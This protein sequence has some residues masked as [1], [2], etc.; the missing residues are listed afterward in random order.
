MPAPAPIEPPAPRP[1][2]QQAPLPQVLAPQ[3]AAP[4][5]TPAA[6]MPP[7]PVTPSAAAPPPLLVSA[8]SSDTDGSIKRLKSKRGE[9][10]QA[11]TGTSGLRIPSSNAIGPASGNN[12]ASNTGLNIPK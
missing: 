4:N 1:V 7:L 10:Q 8:Q 12:N 2:P 11:N 6:P 9:L 5:P 3:A